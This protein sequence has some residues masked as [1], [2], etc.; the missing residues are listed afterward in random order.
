M[1]KTFLFLRISLLYAYH[2]IHVT[3]TPIQRYRQLADRSLPLSSNNT[4]H[5]SYTIQCKDLVPHILTHFE[6]LYMNM[7]HIGLSD[8]AA[9]H[10]ALRLQVYGVTCVYLRHWAVLCLS[11]LLNNCRL[12]QR[13]LT[14]IY[15]NYIYLLIF[16]LFIK[17]NLKKFKSKIHWNFG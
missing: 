14:C 16:L 5:I 13:L 10:Y 7:Y 1:Q 11:L 8:G 4:S 12:W 17:T 2:S 6:P 3:P 9:S 15:C